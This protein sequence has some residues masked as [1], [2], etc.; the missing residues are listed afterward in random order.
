MAAASDR[1]SVCM[2]APRREQCGVTDYSDYLLAPL[3]EL[4]DVRHVTD[5]AGFT[6][7]MNDVD[8]V[9]IQHQ[10]F[11]FGG[12]APWKNRFKEFAD[13]IRVP[14]VLTAHEF[15]EPSGNPAAAA[16]IRATNRRNFLHRAVKRIIVHTEADRARM[17]QSGIPGGISVVRHGVPP[18]P[19]LPPRDE[20]RRALGVEGRFVVTLFGFLSRRKGHALAVEAMRELPDDVALL[21]AGGRHPDDRTGYAEGIQRLIHDG[22]LESRVRITGYLPPDDVAQVMSATDLILAPFTESSGSGSLA[23]A[24]ACGK[25]ILASRIPPHVEIASESVHALKTIHTLHP[26]AVAFE[27]SSLK[28]HPDGLDSLAEGARRYAEAHTYRRMAE[29]TVS[30]YRSVLRR[31]D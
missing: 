6:D 4:A 31:F 9:H 20:A 25:P 15:V 8:V 5:A 22:H 29:E 27:V 17:D 18:T 1:I 16:A 13:R 7:A 30:I 14:A 24:F 19:V 26:G 11:L 21:L 23:L 12:V 2:V 28:N 10:Y 3:R